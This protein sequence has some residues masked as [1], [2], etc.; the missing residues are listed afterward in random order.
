MKG[1]VRVDYSLRNV[2][3]APAA[4]AAAKL[5]PDD[6]PYPIVDL[7]LG[8]KS[9]QAVEAAA[10]KPEQRCEAQF[11]IGEW[12]S[13]ARRQAPGDQGLANRSRH[14]PEG[15]RRTSWR[16]RGAKT[17]EINTASPPKFTVSR[18]ALE[19]DRIVEL[20]DAGSAA[21]K[22]PNWLDATWFVR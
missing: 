2:R 11:Y 17:P 21:R 13:S 8:R 14:L 12:Y 6:W 18:D 9:L 15:F 22:S 3:Q 10:T 7:Y 1:Q 16:G 19:T 5:K 4:K 20:F